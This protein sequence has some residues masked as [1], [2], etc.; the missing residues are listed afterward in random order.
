MQWLS[1]LPLKSIFYAILLFVVGLMIAKRTAQFAEK[2][3]MKHFSRHQASLVRRLIF[4]TIFLG[5]LVSAL[6]QLGFNLTVLI[7]AAG[8]LTVA[9]SFASQ[10]AASNLISGIF[11]IFERP[12][13]IG[14]FIE[15]KGIGGT[16][17]AI[18]L[19]STKL[20]TPDNRVVRIPNETMIKSEITNLSYF[21]TRRIDLLIDISYKNDIDAARQVL[22]ELARE[23]TTVLPE[24]PPTV[25]LSSF[26]ES[27]IQLKY[28][29]WVERANVISTR[30]LLQEK[31]KTRFDEAG[32]EIPYPQ[33]TLHR[34]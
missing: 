33:L 2:Y 31:I 5:F 11:M 32:I 12:F 7:G 34:G 26:A 19:L 29:L 13:L 15:V 30:S 10:T 27:S 3:T 16:V 17:D 25:L 14:D 8:V 22:L 1:T 6:Q 21:P 9:I 24:P 4:Y 23:C 20:K 28:M 18:D